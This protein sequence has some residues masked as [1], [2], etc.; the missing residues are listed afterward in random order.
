VSKV[1]RG[2]P[3]SKA[4]FEVVNEMLAIGDVRVRIDQLGTQL[5]LR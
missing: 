5:A 2:T 1:R 3:G 4:G